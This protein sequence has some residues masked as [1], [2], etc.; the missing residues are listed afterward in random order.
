MNILKNAIDSIKLPMAFDWNNFLSV[1]V[2]GVIRTFS[3][4]IETMLL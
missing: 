1:G 3:E 4:E 2:D